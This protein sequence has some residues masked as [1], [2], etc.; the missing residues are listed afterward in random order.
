MESEEE[1]PELESEETA[2][3]SDTQSSAS[4]AQGNRTTEEHHAPNEPAEGER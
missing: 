2:P 3:D 1:H 4:S